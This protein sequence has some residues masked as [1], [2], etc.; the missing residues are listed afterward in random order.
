MSELAANG[1]SVSGL[2]KVHADSD[3]AYSL[4]DCL[5]L[6]AIVYS[7]PKGRVKFFSSSADSMGGFVGGL[8]G[9]F[10]MG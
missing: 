4:Q 7:S 1:L 2:C 5:T 9:P 3:Q 6:S 10:I 8:N